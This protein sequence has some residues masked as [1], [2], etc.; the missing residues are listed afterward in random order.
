MQI[1]GVDDICIESMISKL[2]IERLQEKSDMVIRKVN[3]LNGDWNEGF[4]YFIASNFGF[5]VNAV[6][7]E[8]LSESLSQHIIAKNKNNSSAIEALIFGQAGF[9][10]QDF[11]EEYPCFLKS[12]YTFLQKKYDLT[13]IDKSMWKFLRMRPQSFPTVRLAQFS[14]LMI[15]SDH[16]LSKILELKDLKLVYNLFENLPVNAYWFSHYHFNKE[17]K[18][19]N[20]QLGKKSIQN[21]MI[22]TVCVFL[23]A[24]GRYTDQLQY[25]DRALDFLED[26]PAEDN[27]IITQYEE[28]GVKPG[29]AFRTQA[30]LQLNKYY[31]SQKKCLNCGIGIK[32][33]KS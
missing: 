1:G 15:S 11:K 21:I 22:N 28:S 10:D 4:N 32:I 14:A 16:L 27:K 23:F 29:N 26:I 19:V 18:N 8:L 3:T 13:P 20:L 5:K 6:P 17:T 7:F 31:C 2:I 30:L 25:V 33:L 24:Y 12:E 9:L